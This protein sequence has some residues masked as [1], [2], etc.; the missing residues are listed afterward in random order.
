[1]DDIDNINDRINLSGHDD[2]SDDR[3]RRIAGIMLQTRQLSSLSVLYALALADCLGMN[4][5]DLMCLGI[6]SS[7]GPATAGQLSAM[8]GLSTGSVTG[9]VDRLERLDLVHRERDEQDR[10]RIMIHLDAGRSQEIG[11]AFVPMLE[12]G[13]QNLEQFTDH[14]LAIIRRYVTSTITHMRE[15]TREARERERCPVLPPDEG[16]N[17]S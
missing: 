1:M 10:R 11:Q 3:D 7:S 2:D 9:L 16:D 14:E 5:S 4:L 17:L 12:A 15:A 8:L 13:W 6:L